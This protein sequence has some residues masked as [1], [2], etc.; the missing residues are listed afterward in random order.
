MGR[1][2]CQKRWKCRHDEEEEQQCLYETLGVSKDAA[3]KDVKKAY[4]KLAMQYHP[5]RVAN[6]EKEAATEQFQKILKAYNILSDPEKRKMYDTTGCTDDDAMNNRTYD[7]W[8]EHWRAMFA[9]INLKDIEAFEAKYK[10]SEMELEALRAAYEEAEG[11]MEG[12]LERVPCCTF[13][14]EARFKAALAPL[15][16]DGTLPRYEAFEVEDTKKRKK[17]EKR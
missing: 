13:E 5:D 1:E 16:A 7:E 12:I 8:Y 11:D 4:Y 14:D 6:T 2:Q 17:R 3:Q 9:K 10:G 15:I